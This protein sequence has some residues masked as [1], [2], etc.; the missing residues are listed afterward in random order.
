MHQRRAIL[1]LFLLGA[2]GARAQEDAPWIIES[3]DSVDYDLNTGIATA[4]NG[5]VVRHGDTLLTA[6]RG[7]VNQLTGEVQAEGEVQLSNA[8]T[9]WHGES[10]RYNFHTRRFVGDDVATARPPLF[11]R[12]STVVGDVS[13]RIAVAAN[14]MVTTDDYATPGY[15]VRAK[16]MTMVPGEYV[17]AKNATLRLGDVPVFWFP[18]Y[19][20]SLGPRRNYWTLT[21]GIRS[22]YGAYLRSTYH[23]Y[24]SERLDT[25]LHFDGFTRRGIGLGPDLNWHLPRFGEGTAKYYYI[26]DQ[27]PGD[28]PQGAP[29]RTDRQRIWLSHQGE[30]ISN[31]TFRAVLAKQSDAQVIRDFFEPE[32]RANVQPNTFV[33]VNQAWPNF[34]LDLLAQP[35]LNDFFETVERLPDVKL[36]GLRQQILETPLYY[37][38]ETSAGWYRR[39]FADGATNAPF[40][41]ARAD[42]FHQILLPW[43]FFGWLNVTPRAGGRFTHYGE[44]DGAGA[45]TTEENRGVFNTGA[46]ASFRA[47]RLW[48]DSRSRFWQVDGVRHIIEP[49][50]NYAYVPTPTVRPPDLPQFDYLVPST[51]L[52]P[53]DYPQFNAHR[54]GGCAECAPARPCATNCRLAATGK[55]TTWSTGR[56]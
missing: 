51:R 29:I 43:N 23:W 47:S 28:D 34:T 41:A 53:I 50:L 32:Y 1:L 55:W 10:M 13:N 46:E 24:W 48:T 25:D 3:Q 4:T 5:I 16:T 15:S 35:R 38:S 31:L 33:E 8:E 44:A 6:R 42:T 17:E 36:S 45:T 19:K 26:R 27:D 54:C 18:Y 52:L 12:G 37:E 49:T 21:P 22:R 40:S 2:F 20:K 14:A 39:K 56:S 7:Q 30:I 11:F 9:L